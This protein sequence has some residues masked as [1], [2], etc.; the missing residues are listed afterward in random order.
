MICLTDF[1]LSQSGSSSS[2]LSHIIEEVTRATAVRPQNF[3]IRIDYIVGS[4]HDRLLVNLLQAKQDS[5]Q[6]LYLVSEAR[7]EVLRM[8]LPQTFNNVVVPVVVVNQRL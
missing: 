6:A 4:L 2:I 5:L 3:A 7:E 8:A 1:F